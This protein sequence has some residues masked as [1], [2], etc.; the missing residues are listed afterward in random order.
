MM[1]MTNSPVVDQRLRFAGASPPASRWQHCTGRLMD[2]AAG[3]L[4]TDG[5]HA[6]ASQTYGS[7]DWLIVRTVVHEAGHAAV[8]RVFGFAA[9]IVINRPGDGVCIFRGSDADRDIQT[10]RLIGLAGSVAAEIATYGGD[11]GSAPIIRTLNWPSALS[12][13][14]AA[15]AGKFDD[16][17]IKDCECLVRDLWAAIA[18]EA[19]SEL[20]AN[21]ERLGGAQ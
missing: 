6:A 20:A 2:L 1:H 11:S 3:A 14:D 8:A 16:R 7:N 9:T 15:M 12:P 10:R 19:R 17:D 13:S 18:A 21:L 4:R 5:M